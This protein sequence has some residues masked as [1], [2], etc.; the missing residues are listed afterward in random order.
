MSFQEKEAWIQHLFKNN[1]NGKNKVNY[2]CK[3]L[4]VPSI[5]ICAA[6]K[7]NKLA[8]VCVWSE[9]LKFKQLKVLTPPVLILATLCC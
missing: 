2:F 6:Y 8:S 7:I 5:V 4:R 3:P 9:G 1:N